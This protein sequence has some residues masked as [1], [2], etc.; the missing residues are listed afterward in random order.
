MR[1]VSPGNGKEEEMKRK[2]IMLAIAIIAALVFAI[3]YSYHSYFRLL[4]IR[5]TMHLDLPGWLK[6][7]LLGWR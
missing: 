5:W 2:K 1:D 4:V 3:W 6:A 7:W